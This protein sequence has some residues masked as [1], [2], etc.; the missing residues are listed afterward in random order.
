MNFDILWR[1]ILLSAIWGA[2]FLFMRV[3]VPE[4]G[5]VPLILIRVF[6]AALVLFPFLLNA[7]SRKVIANHAGRLLVLG[8]LNSVIPF[9]LLAFATLRIEAG[10][11]SLLNATTPLFAAV[12]GAALLAQAVTRN[13]F[14]G[15]FLGIVGV[16]IISYDR[17]SFNPGGTGWAVIAALCAAMSYG[18]AGHY[19]RQ[20]LK[21]VPASTLAAGSMVAATLVLTIPGILL[22]P[23]TAVSVTS[24]S[25]A[26]TLAIVCTAA[27]YLLY[28]HIIE[29]AGA[30]IGATVTFLIPVFAVVWGMI[31]L[32]EQ[33]DAPMVTGM[34]VTLF[35][36]A[37]A[38]NVFPRRLF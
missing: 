35:G 3:S 23:T 11:A 29:H 17:L 33:V 1:L 21:N 19:A 20:R 16:A 4:F 31:F 2:S 34:I 32:G 38:I 6:G 25:C 13:Q 36:T 8:L 26:I 37:L 14:F 10:F 27:A 28:F 9:C 22:W 15:I 5:P 12:V 24:W 7:S 18:L 30:L